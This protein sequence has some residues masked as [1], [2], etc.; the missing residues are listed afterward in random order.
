MMWTNSSGLLVSCDSQNIEEILV[1]IKYLKGTLT[2]R[3]TY[4]P[5]LGKF[6]IG[7]KEETTNFVMT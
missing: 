6:E 7:I 4:R 3:Q 1:L 5:L 2:L